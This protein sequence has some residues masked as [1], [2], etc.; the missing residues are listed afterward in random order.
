MAT[1]WRRRDGRHDRDR[2]YAANPS[3][4][5]RPAIVR[6]ACQQLAG[7]KRTLEKRYLRKSETLPLGC[8]RKLE[9]KSIAFLR[10]AYEPPDHDLPESGNDPPALNSRALPGGALQLGQGTLSICFGARSITRSFGNETTSAQRFVILHYL[11]RGCSLIR[12]NC[13]GTNRPDWTLFRR[14]GLRGHWLI[15]LT[16]YRDT[17]CAHHLRARR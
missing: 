1:G 4:P 8:R 11:L 3:A 2:A 14:R 16:R 12:S 17:A 9:K 6:E 10:I 15:W 7:E 5:A 13:K